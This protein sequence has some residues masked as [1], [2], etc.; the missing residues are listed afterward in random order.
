MPISDRMNWARMDPSSAGVAVDAARL[1]ADELAG[2]ELDDTLTHLVD[3]RRR[4]GS[5]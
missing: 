1:I 2:L 3:D 5:P 4:R